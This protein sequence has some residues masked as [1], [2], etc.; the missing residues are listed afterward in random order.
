M[1]KNPLKTTIAT[2][3]KNPE[4]ILD[5]YLLSPITATAYES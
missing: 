5:E 2:Y 3:L 1:G 4:D